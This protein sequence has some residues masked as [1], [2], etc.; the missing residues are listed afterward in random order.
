MALFKRLI[1]WYQRCRICS[2]GG[3]CLQGSG[4][5]QVQAQ[6][7]ELKPAEPLKFGQLYQCSKC[8]Q[9][10]YLDER[11]QWLRRVDGDFLP[12]VHHW[13]RNRFIL[14]DAMLGALAKI[15]GVGDF[16]NRSISIPCQVR[17]ATGQQHQKAVVLIS[18]QPPLNGTDPGKIHWAE[19]IIAVAPSPFALPLD[20]R[21]ASLAKEEESMGFAP[22]NVVDDNGAEYTLAQESCFFDHNGVKGKRIKLSARRKRGPEIVMPDPAQAYYHID[23]FDGCEKL[24]LH[25]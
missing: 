14:P 1:A 21:R 9:S 12:L 8:L 11:K 15:G 22:V 16:L 2:S 6:F 17:N 23:W 3:I 10:W 13:N 18:N 24:F 19:E 4:L 5:S 25:S 7:P 20:V